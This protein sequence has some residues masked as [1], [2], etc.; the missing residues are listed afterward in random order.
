[1]EI[2]FS[3]EQM[4]VLRETLE[5]EVRVM[6]VEVHRTDHLPYKQRLQRRLEMI[7]KMLDE[8]KM[9]CA[10]ATVSEAAMAI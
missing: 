2:R 9:S 10:A 8:V 6:E 7:Q 5:K 1:M 3:G 4:E